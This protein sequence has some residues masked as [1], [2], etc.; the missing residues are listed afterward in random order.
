MTGAVS[1]PPLPPWTRT[2]AVVAPTA[3]L[4]VTWAVDAG[5]SPPE[6]PPPPTTAF[7]IAPL[8]PPSFTRLVA[9]TPSLLPPF[10]T[11][12]V[13]TA[14]P[15]PPVAGAGSVP[16]RPD[17]FVVFA[18]EADDVPPLLGLLPLPAD[19]A[20]A[21]LL[22]RPAA[23]V[24]VDELPSF[25]KSATIWHPT[26]SEESKMRFDTKTRRNIGNYLSSKN[27]ITVEG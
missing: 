21:A 24:P 3:P 18:S 10:T 2:L 16:L 25:S 14:P 1:A 4:L 6:V 15:A 27:L 17:E 12:G 26:A 22:A 5:V 7:V 9:I 19:D 11:T 20:F 13:V 23:P 8:V